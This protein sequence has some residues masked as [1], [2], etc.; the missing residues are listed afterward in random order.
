MNP[1]TTGT[2]CIKCGAVFARISNGTPPNVGDRAARVSAAFAHLRTESAFRATEAPGS[3]AVPPEAIEAEILPATPNGWQK[4]AARK[5][6]RVYFGLLDL[7]LESLERIPGEAE[8][9]DTSDVE[10][11]L[12]RSLAT[13]FPD[14]TLSPG[15]DLILACGF[16]AANAW[17]G[18]KR[19]PSQGPK[20]KPSP[21]PTAPTTDKPTEPPPQA[22]V[23]AA[24]GALT[25]FGGQTGFSGG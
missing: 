12:A 19:V 6:R 8:I 10:D 25:V 14:G 4:G 9:D 11:S 5:I 23:V 17:A 22:T 1:P 3:T 24:K 18:S 20:A 16:A 7:V 2:A 13:W 21:S 15:K